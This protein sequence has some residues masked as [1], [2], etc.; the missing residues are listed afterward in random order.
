[1][2]EL[3]WSPNFLHQSIGRL[4]RMFKWGVSEEL[5]PT[6]VAWAPELASR[7][8]H[9]GAVL[10]MNTSFVDLWFGSAAFAG[11]LTGEERD[12]LFLEL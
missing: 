2:I 7:A 11:R 5:A 9:A 12:N 4:L 1:M 10:T 8:A 3:G 6:N